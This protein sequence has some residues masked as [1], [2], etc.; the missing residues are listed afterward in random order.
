MN[1]SARPK[2]TFTLDKPDNLVE[3]FE[4]AVA[5][6]AD[7]EWMGTKN[8]DGQYEW[9]T[10]GQ[11]A[12][13]IDN[14]RAG[15]AGLGVGPGDSVGI[16][17]NNSVAWA[18]AGFAT[19]GLRA[20]FV[21]MYKVELEKTWK[22]IVKDSLVKVLF[23][24]GQDIYDKVK[25]WPSEIESLKKIIRIEG[26]GPDT[27]ADLEAAGSRSPVK[28]VRPDPDEIAGLIYTSGTTGDPKG[29]LLSHGNFSSNVHSIQK[30]YSNLDHTV[31]TLSFLPWAHSYGQTAELNLMIKLGG[32]TGFAESPQTIVSDIA[33]VKPNF[34]VAVPRVFNRIYDGLNARMKERG[35]I[36]KLLFDMG[37]AAGQKRRTLARKGKTS[38]VA[39]LKYSIADKIVFA[40]IR[41]QFGGRLA[42]SASSSAA[43]NPGIAEFFFDIGIAIYEAWG[44]TEI[45]PAGACNGPGA[46]KIGSC[47]RAIDKVIFEI[48]KSVV[49]DPNGREGELIVYG[50]NVMKGYH[51]KPEETRATMT[52]D[53][54]LRTGDRA[55]IDEDGYLYITGRIKE[56]FKLEN[57]KFVYPA[58]MQEE[59][60]V[61]P[62]VEQVMIYGLNRPFTIAIV[63]PDFAVMSRI[64][65]ERGLSTEPA[66]IVSDPSLKE[67]MQNEI[68]SHLKGKFGSYEIP[69][70]FLFLAEGFTLQ[71]GLLTQ[72]FK[73][74]R[75]EVIKRYQDQVEALY[76]AE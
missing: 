64:A 46:Y 30:V 25:N 21:P 37:V 68:T 39:N 40:K 45:S 56:Q 22:Y 49:D 10:Y 5:R 48:D 42:Q 71:N 17:D 34:L 62:C 2:Y 20:R 65:A 51:N 43:L 28:A 72:T 61:V 74:K 31:R 9:I 58:A 66:Q 32:S 75:Q 41:E 24:A 55:Y 47:G 76:A 50:P 70:R 52:E 15:L 73:L 57:G 44:M 3:L 36:A 6:F 19:Y 33:V 63:V 59:I 7:K 69:R 12:E 14:C 13:R 23:V 53:G 11:A 8:R 18:V 35:G 54:G 4:Q 60:T 26:D 29:V 16:I 1:Q 38:A 67:Y 27:M